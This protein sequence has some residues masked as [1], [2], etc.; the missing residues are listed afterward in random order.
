MIIN[1]SFHNHSKKQ[2]WTSSFSIS[3]GLIE[4]YSS[5]D[6]NSP[7]LFTN[8]ISNPKKN[9]ISKIFKKNVYIVYTL[10]KIFLNAQPYPVFVIG[11]VV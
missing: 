11:P 8:N 3:S 9:I 1:P 5:F 4:S 2:R 7:Y 6:T 10:N